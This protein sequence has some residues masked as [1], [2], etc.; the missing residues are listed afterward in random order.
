MMAGYSRNIK[1]KTTMATTTTPATT[2]TA[3]TT[4]TTPAVYAGAQSAYTKAVQSI[5]NHIALN[6]LVTKAVAN[7]IL[8]PVETAYIQG[9]KRRKTTADAY[10]AVMQVLSAKLAPIVDTTGK[11]YDSIAASIK[12]L[13]A[14]ALGQAMLGVDG[15]E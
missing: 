15:D 9:I 12:G 6:M 8:Q 13:T 4:T 3:T 2:T 14:D 10:K 7:K 1:D 5:D 11:D